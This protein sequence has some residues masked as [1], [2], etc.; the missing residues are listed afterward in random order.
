VLRSEVRSY[1]EKKAQEFDLEFLG[2]VSPEYSKDAEFYQDGLTKSSFESL[3]YLANY[4]EL[5][6]NPALVLENCQSVLVFALNYYE[7]PEPPPR[8]ALYAQMEDYHRLLKRKT[9]QLMEQINH[10]LT[11]DDFSYRVCVDTAPVLEKALAKKTPG[12][13]QGKNTLLIHKDLGSFLLLGFV[14]TTWKLPYDQTSEIDLA[15]KSKTG[16]CG[17]C[18]LC[19]TACPTGAL[20]QDYTLKIEKCLSYWTIEQRGPIPFEYW[21]WL[22][23]YYFGCDLCQLACPYN[24]ASKIKER[25][26]SVPKR[27]YPDLWSVATMDQAAYEKYFGGTAMTRAKKEGLQRNALIAMTVTHHPRLKEAVKYLDD[28]NLYPIPETLKQIREFC[29]L[30]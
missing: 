17:P 8:V 21:P 15:R 5:R 4:Q 22:K 18:N 14:F 20:N 19:Q 30:R 23:E 1:L 9:T 11:A 7:K 25:P 2:I 3:P 10:E 12:S 27:E 6:K 29:A 26:T 13:F 16:G 24:K 28:C